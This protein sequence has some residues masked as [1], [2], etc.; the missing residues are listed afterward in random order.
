MC[1]SVPSLHDIQ[2]NKL[3]QDDLQEPTTIQIDK[4]LARCWRHHNFV[5]LLFYAFPTNNL[6]SFGITFQRLEGLIINKEI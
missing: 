3:W 2:S 4:S 6:Y 5:Q 1:S